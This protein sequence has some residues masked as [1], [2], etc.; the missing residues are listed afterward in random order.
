MTPNEIITEA[1]YNIYGASTPDASVQTRASSVLKRLYDQVQRKVPWWFLRQGLESLAGNTDLSEFHIDGM[2]EV[3]GS[4]IYMAKAED[5]VHIVVQEGNWGYLYTYDDLTL[6]MRRFEGINTGNPIVIDR[7]TGKLYQ[8]DAANDKVQ[9]LSSMGEVITEYSVSSSSLATG[10][11]IRNGVMYFFIGTTIFSCVLSTMQ[12]TSLATVTGAVLGLVATD[13]GV[14]ILRTD[15]KWKTSFYSF[16]QG[17]IIELTSGTQIVWTNT[18]FDGVNVFLGDPSAARLIS[19][20]DSGVTEK[21]SVVLFDRANMICGDSN[22]IYFMIATNNKYTMYRMTKRQPGNIFSI[23][24]E[25]GERLSRIQGC[26]YSKYSS[27]TGDSPKYYSDQQTIWQN[28]ILSYYPES[29]GVKI[30]IDAIVYNEID[31]SYADAVCMNLEDYLIKKLT[32]EISLM[33]EYA[34]RYSAYSQAAELALQEKI[35][36][37]CKFT[38]QEFEPGYADV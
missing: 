26:D 35:E 10:N 9:L 13:S 18:G 1:L 21:E 29:Q 7:A 30:T 36:E 5:K 12:M 6:S 14:Y 23:T 11:S 15:S 38:A 19:V 28:R 31:N 37:N 20:S 22:C 3:P 17:S 33:T 4:P 16:A 8:I 27:M 32:A 25:N 24:T 2:V 34:D